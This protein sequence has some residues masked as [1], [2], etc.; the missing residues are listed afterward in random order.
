MTNNSVSG[1]VQNV[2]N[3]DELILSVLGYGKSYNP[4]K[5]SFKI[6]SLQALSTSAKSAIDEV[7][8]ARPNYGNAV[9]ARE[10]AFEPLDKL[11]TRVMSA[12]I[13]TDTTTQVDDHVR[14]LVLKIHG[15]RINPKKT[16]EEK[17]ALEAKGKVVKEISATQ[18]G[19]ESRLDN[20]D[21]LIKLLSTLPEYVPNEAELKVES[22]MDLYTSLRIKNTAVSNTSLPLKNARIVRNDII[23]K[24]KTGL[25]DVALDTKVYIKS[26]YGATSP[27]YKQIAKLHFK[28]VPL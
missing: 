13:A 1:H 10:A 9:A 14:S 23:S 27:Q 11:V 22:L 7:N 25:V 4:T 5:E 16:E 6:A 2:A 18:T 19:Y 8:F 17:K 21:Q 20:L 26:I 3:L 24:P 12:V 28:A 15:T